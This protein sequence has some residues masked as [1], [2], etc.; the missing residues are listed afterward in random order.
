VKEDK[1]KKRKEKKRKEKRTNV[2]YNFSS[3]SKKIFFVLLF[4]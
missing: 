2:G 3:S 4:T 1:E